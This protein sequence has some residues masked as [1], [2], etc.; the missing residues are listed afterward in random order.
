MEKAKDDFLIHVLE[1]VLVDIENLTYR[2]MFGGYGIYK[3]GI[4]FAIIAFNEL[5][6]KVGANN[7]DEYKKKESHPFVYDRK[8]HK[9]TTMSYWL[10]PDEIMHDKEQIIKWVN[11]AVTASQE[12]KRK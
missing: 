7:I 4:I 9:S 8:G 10:V 3:D 6:F 11:K 1:D 12:S 2:A 5:Y